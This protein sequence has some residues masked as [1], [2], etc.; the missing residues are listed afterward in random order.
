MS[1]DANTPSEG[2]FVFDST[3]LD[4]VDGDGTRFYLDIVVAANG[5]I[6]AFR[7]RQEGTDN[8]KWQGAYE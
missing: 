2:P 8:E 4:I 5:T 1:G 7:I 6:V 3:R